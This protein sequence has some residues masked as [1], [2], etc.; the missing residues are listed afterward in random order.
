MMRCTHLL[1]V[2]KNATTSPT[3][4]QCHF[5]QAACERLKEDP[6]S[7]VLSAGYR[8]EDEVT[9]E[10]HLQSGGDFDYIFALKHQVGC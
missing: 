1:F 5:L 10:E 3:V 8:I 4:D 7:Y 2:Q 6:L 9:L